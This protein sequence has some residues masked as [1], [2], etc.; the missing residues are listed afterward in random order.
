MI[1]KTKKCIKL[2]LFSF[3]LK[4]YWKVR[5]IFKRPKIGFYFGK[6][7]SC[8][9]HTFASSNNIPKILAI[10]SSDVSYKYKYD[11][12]RHEEDPNFAIILFRKYIFAI[13]FYMSYKDELRDVVN[14]SIEYW[15]F[16]LNYL[17]DKNLVKS[18]K[19]SYGWERTSKLN[20]DNKYIIPLLE[21]TLNKRGLKIFKK[22]W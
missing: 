1:Y 6:W 13:T 18:F 22:E 9:I 3:P 21:F 11:S 2:C 10:W 12:P 16:I 5:K 19:K 15:E 17:E 4:T 7:S 14:G 8:P 20:K